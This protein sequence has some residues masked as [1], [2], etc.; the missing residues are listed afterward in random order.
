MAIILG[1]P[2][3]G[4]LETLQYANKKFNWSDKWIIGISHSYAFKAWLLARLTGKKC[5]YYCIDFYTYKISSGFFDNI[6]IWFSIKLDKFLCNHVDEVW[7]ISEMI[8][9][10]RWE[11]SRYMRNSKI[12]PLSYPPDYFRW[13]YDIFN[14]GIFVGLV[15]YGKKIWPNKT[16]AELEGKIPLDKLLNRISEYSCGISVWEKDGN[17]Y[18]GDPGKTKLYL[19][20]GIPVIMT[21]NTPF[22][23]IV[24]ETKA[25]IVLQRYSKR[26]AERAYRRIMNKYSFYKRNVRKTWRYIN[27][28]KVFGSLR[29]LEQ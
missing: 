25:G 17:N 24:E 20:C 16:R 21:K 7:D 18:Y 22:A 8:N 9:V 6:W 23:H 2:I 28:D 3:F 14:C 15:P 5:V 11:Y 4:R 10:G 27:A 13:S 29:L 1:K 12:V 19:A 26:D